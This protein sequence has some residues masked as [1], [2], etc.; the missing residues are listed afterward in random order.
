MHSMLKSAASG[1]ATRCSFRAL[2]GTTL[3]VAI[4]GY[5]I[6]CAVQSFRVRGTSMEP[7]LHDGQYVV[8]DRVVYRYLHPPRRGD[9]VVFKDSD[10]SGGEVV[11][12]VVGLPGE[13]LELR[14]ACVYVEGQLLVEPYLAAP[15]AGS[16]GPKQIS[17]DEYFVLGD[18]RLRSTD[19]RSWGG[20]PGTRIVGKVRFQL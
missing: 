20:L 11:K 12:R 15:S 14:S 13:R 19:S 5:A 3:A 17:P 6:R 7:T 9:I 4:F 2:V 10:G 1:R 8:V 16:W 18:N